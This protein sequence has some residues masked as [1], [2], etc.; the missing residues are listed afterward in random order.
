MNNEERAILSQDSLTFNREK[1]R[2]TLLSLLTPSM[3]I[4]FPLHR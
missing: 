4:I 2:F 3:R 1:N